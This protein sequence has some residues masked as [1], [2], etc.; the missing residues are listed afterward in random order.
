M[1]IR[2]LCGLVILALSASRP[3]SS[4]ADWAFVPP[5]PPA[6]G[7]A[8]LRFVD[9]TSFDNVWA[10]GVWQPAAYRCLAEHFDG[11][12][13]TQFPT[14]DAPL[15]D[16]HLE[17]VVAI[18]TE[19]AMAV[20]THTPVGT[21]AQPLAI[22]WN[23]SDWVLIPAPENPGGRSFNAVDH[24]PSGTTWVAGFEAGRAFLARR[25]GGSWDL[26]F[27]PQVGSFRNRF[28]AMH[29]R[30]DAE[31]WVV[32]TQSDGFG[33]FEILLQR[34]DGD[35]NWTT[36]NVPS[37]N[38]LDAMQGVVAFARDDAWAVGYYYHI[39]LYFYQPLILHY[40]GTGWTPAALPQYPEGSARL[41]GIAATAPNDIYAAGTY[42]TA[43]GTPRPF[44]LHYDG[45]GWTDV[46]LPPTGGRGEWFQGM[47]ATADGAVWAVGQ[48]FDGTTTEPIAFR[49]SSAM[50]GV[51]EPGP[52]AV[53]QQF[54]LSPAAPNPFRFETSL[55][56]SL[57]RPS[58]VR[59]RVW[60]VSGRLVRTLVDRQM[61]GG[62]HVVQWDGRD[63][64]GDQVGG[65]G[66]LT[67][68]EVG[69]EARSRKIV[70][71]R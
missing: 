33:E 16:G 34:Y 59:L 10:V 27:A 55:R 3:E 56:F 14:P 63:A 41:E 15:N 25:N 22:E 58:R 2:T 37:P 42:A 24:T 6:G 38:S 62:D 53:A 40:D 46:T 30:S 47:A 48:Y 49:K 8:M 44:M 1:K 65:G 50:T 71:V 66:Y 31:I 26:E 57:D 43:N 64:R 67:R 36:F 4:Q 20:G 12:S 18:S 7:E 69:S 5:E 60:D 68:L 35:S 39:P 61:D 21:T 29:A 45:V 11:A 28:Y 17:G 51:G 32:G 54:T 13:W 23:G 52:N 70:L 19:R 9:G